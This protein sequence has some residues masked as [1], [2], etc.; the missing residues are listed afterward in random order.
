MVVAADEQLHEPGADE[1]WQESFYFNWSEPDGSGYG[2]ARIGY[3]HAA[4]KVDGVL[5]DDARRPAGVHLP[6]G[7][8]RHGRRRHPAAGVRAARQP[9]ELHDARAA[10]ALAHRLRTGQGRGRPDLDRLP[11]S[12]RLPRRPR[13][14][15]RQG[16]GARHR[17]RALRAVRCGARDGRVRRQAPRVRRPRPSRQVLGRARLGRD[18]RLGVAVGAVRRGPRLQRDRLVPAGRRR[19]HPRRLH[20]ARR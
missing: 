19:D 10:G 14:A 4:R 13:A 12:A 6:G 17:A 15:R 3:N 16:R 20:H 1:H 9:P 2:L 7:R 18:P 11:P 8:P 5:L